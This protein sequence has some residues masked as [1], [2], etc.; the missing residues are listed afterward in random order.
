M[1]TEEN[2]SNCDARIVEIF[3]ISV[4]PEIQNLPPMKAKKAG[5]A[6]L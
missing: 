4:G 2:D 3:V 6:A 5:A 1:A